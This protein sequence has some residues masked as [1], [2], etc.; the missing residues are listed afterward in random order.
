MGTRI[1]K[2]IHTSNPRLLVREPF[3]DGHGGGHPVGCCEGC[4]DHPGNRHQHTPARP[5]QNLMP[6]GTAM[7]MSKGA[8]RGTAITMGRHRHTFP[9]GRQKPFKTG[10]TVGILKGAGM[11]TAIAMGSASAHTRPTVPEPLGE[12]HSVGHPKGAANLI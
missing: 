12:G 11:G 1:T 2:A 6:T 10:T 3:P 8:A 5:C 7:G 4:G 9:R